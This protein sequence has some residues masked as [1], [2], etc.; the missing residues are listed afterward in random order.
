MWRFAIKT[1]KRMLGP[2]RI[3]EKKKAGVYTALNI[4]LLLGSRVVLWKKMEMTFWKK[5]LQVEFRCE[6]TEIKHNKHTNHLFYAV[7]FDTVIRH[8]GGPRHCR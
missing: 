4:G 8:Y 6:M 1:F 2:S 5:L 7:K 3:T